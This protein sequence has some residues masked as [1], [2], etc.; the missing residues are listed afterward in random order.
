RPTDGRWPAAVAA[1]G[2]LGT[3]R[4]AVRA[5]ERI[6]KLGIAVDGE[7][8]HSKGYTPIVADQRGAVDGNASSTH[9]AGGLRLDYDLGDSKLHAGLRVF[10]ESLDAGTQHTTADV[11]TISY[12]AGWEMVR[13]PGR[14]GVQAF[15][16]NQR[17]DQ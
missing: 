3:G 10:D 1:G 8:L 6:D 9:G 4:F 7:G 11:R 16:G 14:L 2:S 12:E 17:F 5:T 13:E 15:G